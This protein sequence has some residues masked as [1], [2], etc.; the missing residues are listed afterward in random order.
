MLRRIRCSVLGI[1]SGLMLWV[2]LPAAAA[3]APVTWDHLVR[4]KARGFDQVYLLPGADFRAYAKVL[5]DP[6]QVAF[7][8]D[9]LR[10]VNASRTGSSRVT[11][12]DAAKIAERTRTGTAKVFADAFR[13]AG[14]E[15]VS[16]PGADVLRVSPNVIDLYITAPDTMSAGRSRTYTVDAGEATIVLEAHDSVAG[17][18]LGR[19]VGRDRAGGQG[20]MRLSWATDVS[21]TAD[22]DRL[23]AR[24]ATLCAKGLSALKALSPLSLE[25]SPT[26]VQTLPKPA[27]P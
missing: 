24:W 6:V 25:S 7:R 22:F 3:P 17:T 2:A 4:V 15:V 10:D 16:D 21:N 27:K 18:A 14:Y 13:A 5:I 26:G 12:E 11:P 23:Y 1:L 8:K 9:W 20:G 19:A